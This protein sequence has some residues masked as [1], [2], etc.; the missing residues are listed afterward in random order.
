MTLKN[1]DRL[2]SVEAIKENFES[3]NYICNTQIAT[4][5]FLAYH[6]EKP[7]L[8]EGPPGVGKTELQHIALAGHA[9][10]AHALGAQQVGIGFYAIAN[11]QAEFRAV[12]VGR[13]LLQACFRVHLL[14]QRAANFGL[15]RGR[16][17]RHSSAP[18]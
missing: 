17:R 16:C 5:V 13:W 12:D 6:L 10:I 9:A 7:I 18:R 4:A 14:Q 11:Q 3:R 2:S 8:I 1:A 15:S